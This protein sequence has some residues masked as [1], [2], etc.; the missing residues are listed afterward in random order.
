MENESTFQR[1][2]SELSL[3]DRKELHSKLHSQSGFSTEPLYK[4]ETENSGFDISMSYE[5]IP[6]YIRLWYFILGL[7]KNSNPIKVYEDQLIAKLGIEIQNKTP[8]LFEYHDAILLPKLFFLLGDLKDASRFF[9]SALDISVN[10]DKGAFFAFLASLEMD[11][12]HQ[13]L[14]NETNPQTL[15]QKFPEA[16]NSELAEKASKNMD[17]IFASISETQRNVMYYDART[18]QCLKELSAFL[19]DRLLLAFHADPSAEGH[20]CSAKMVKDQLITLSNILY[21]FSGTPSLSLL[22]SLFVFVLPEQMGN[23]EFDLEAEVKRLLAQAENA[24]DMIRQFNASVPLT[25]IIRCVTRDFNF[26]PRAVSGGEDWFVVYKDYWKKH[27][28]EQFASFGKQR[29]KIILVQSFKTFLNN[30]SLEVSPNISSETNPN[31]IPASGAMGLSFLAAFYSEVFLSVINN[32]LRTILLDGEFYKREN[33]TV[34][35]EAYNNIMKID[36]KIKKFEGKISEEGDYGKRYSLAK[37]EITSLPVKRKKIQIVTQEVNEEIQEIINSTQESF[38][39]MIEVLQ[40]IIKHET[41]G[42][43]DT[44]SNLA[45]LSAAKDK[46]FSDAVSQAKS[47][48]E[49]AS[50]LLKEANLLELESIIMPGD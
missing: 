22:E 8:D 43:Y 34:F 25:K 33:R 2:A 10:R 42:K 32:I 14:T 31:G 3:E 35:T 1:L 27:T 17:D 29:R 11:D 20:I 50:S 6:W 40:G 46:P 21:S 16:M 24:L 49:E 23:I 13:R 7:L 48:L 19:F 37:S 45:S 15:M 44:L 38:K 28:D 36:E 12:I 4:E 30:A 26:S 5:K 9:Y 47:K 39:T 41:G 18:L